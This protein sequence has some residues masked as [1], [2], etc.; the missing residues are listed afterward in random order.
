MRS[1]VHRVEQH[2]L[3][4]SA[5]SAS[6]RLLLDCLRSDR[7]QRQRGK[8]VV[9]E[10]RAVS[11]FEK[12]K[13]KSP[14]RGPGQEAHSKW[15]PLAANKSVYCWTSENFGSFKIR[16]RSPSESA[17]RAA[18]I[19]IRPMNLV[20][21]RIRFRSAHNEADRGLSGTE[22]SLGDQTKLDEVLRFDLL[23]QRTQ[24]LLRRVHLPCA[25]DDRCRSR[26][27]RDRRKS[28]RARC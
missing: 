24:I 19:G 3:H 16:I 23:E 26:R 7:L 15:T 14:S 13:G 6:A 10:K 9:G 11:T 20:A 12:R 18:V 27:L 22:N 1:L 28:S 25:A 2:I 5:K 4:D 21:A 8:A 17:F